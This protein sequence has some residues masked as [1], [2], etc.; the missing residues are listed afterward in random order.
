M[1]R[2]RGRPRRFPACPVCG[3]GLLVMYTKQAGHCRNVGCACAACGVKLRYVCA[4]EHGYWHR[5]RDLRAER[6]GGLHDVG[7]SG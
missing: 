3:G 7:G 6:S 2:R 5:I 4:G 1:A